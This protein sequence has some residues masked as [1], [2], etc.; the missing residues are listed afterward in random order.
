MDQAA[1]RA[2]REQLSV[3]QLPVGRVA[4]M[5][6]VTVRT[7]HHYERVGLLTPSGRTAS[8]YR[9]YDPQ[10]LARLRRILGYRDLGF[11]L[12]EIGALLDGEADPL[13]H[14]RT[15]HRM[16]GRRLAQVRRTLENVEKMMDAHDSGIRLTPAEMLDVFGDDDPTRYAAEAKERWGDTDAYAQSHR[17]TSQYT[18]ADWQQNKAEAAAVNQAFASAMADGEP[19]DGP[20]A[21]AAAQ[22]HRDHIGR[23]YYDVPAQLHTG[24]ADLYLADPRFTKHYEDVAPGLAQYVHD[25]IYANALRD[26]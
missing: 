9:L 5:S 18:A 15:Q 20:R 24:L 4:R 12:E 17:R 26:V 10:D 6:G 11:G 3:D 21:M 22:A 19:A 7:L 25:A 8:G 23:W 14:L 16:L 1:E 13:E 2:G